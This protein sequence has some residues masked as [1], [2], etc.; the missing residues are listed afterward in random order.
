V[1]LAVAVVDVQ[2]SGS[3]V[4]E[5]RTNVGD[6]RRRDHHAEE[7]HQLRRR[8]GGAEGKDILV[9]LDRM[10]VWE[11]GQVARIVEHSIPLG[12]DESRVVLTEAL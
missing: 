1:R 6:S 12:L 4:K 2:A 11:R 7:L 8:R 9:P 10:I 5:L 3:E